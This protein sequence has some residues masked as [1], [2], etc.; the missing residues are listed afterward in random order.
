MELSQTD[1][2]PPVVDR[3]E[4]TFTET[5]KS[6]LSYVREFEEIYAVYFVDVCIVHM[7][8]DMVP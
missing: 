4:A 7:V 1:H 6:M 5:M 8:E 2:N 3:R